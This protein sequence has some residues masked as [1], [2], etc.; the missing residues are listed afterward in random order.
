MLRMQDLTAAARAL[1]PCGGRT[2]SHAHSCAHSTSPLMQEGRKRPRPSC[3][4]K[5]EGEATGREAQKEKGR[6][7][8]QIAATRTLG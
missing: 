3:K 8:E 5:E 1:K 7:N 4:N 6:R 2:L